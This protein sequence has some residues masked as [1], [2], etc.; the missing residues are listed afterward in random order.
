MERAICTKVF[1]TKYLKTKRVKYLHVIFTDHLDEHY[2]TFE[3]FCVTSGF[4]YLALIFSFFVIKLE[5]LVGKTLIEIES[6]VA[7]QTKKSTILFLSNQSASDNILP[8]LKGYLKRILNLV[9]E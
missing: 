4:V 1:R 7:K 2:C 6:A 3:Q 5:S 8:P 9:L